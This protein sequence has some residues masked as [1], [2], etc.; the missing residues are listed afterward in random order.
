MKLRHLLVLI[1]L[2]TP[3]VWGKQY[4]FEALITNNT[5]K[6]FF[7]SSFSD[8]D[9]FSSN[10]GILQPHQSTS[11]HFA[12]DRKPYPRAVIRLQK[13]FNRNDY[14]NFV[15]LNNS[16]QILGCKAPYACSATYLNPN[17]INFVIV[18]SK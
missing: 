1:A 4:S 12:Y 2:L 16:Y 11:I 5:N 18:S 9:S 14:I 8:G 6:N 13:S 7:V 17:K 3:S 10:A 15:L